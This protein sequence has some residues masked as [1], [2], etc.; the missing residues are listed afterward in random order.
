MLYMK[1]NTLCQ[2]FDTFFNQKIV[3]FTN[4]EQ[5]QTYETHSNKHKHTSVN[6][7]ICSRT[8]TT[9]YT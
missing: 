4:I 8:V 2:E 3:L 9:N 1:T 7:S 6:I 5:K